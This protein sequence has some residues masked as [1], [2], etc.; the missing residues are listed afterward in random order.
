MKT[1]AVALR[2]LGPALS[3][4]NAF[5]IL[6]GIETLPLRMD[7]HCANAWPWPRSW[8]RTRRLRGEL[9]GLAFEPV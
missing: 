3:P 4:Q 8:R 1:R 9:R 5:Y 7:R 2:D 6:T